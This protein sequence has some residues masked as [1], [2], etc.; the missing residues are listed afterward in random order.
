MLES[1]YTLKVHV[2]TALGQI[3]K[4]EHMF[5]DDEWEFMCDLIEALQPCEQDKRDMSSQ[6]YPSISIVKSAL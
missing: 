3:N 1:L 6:L 4:M 2:S 5:S